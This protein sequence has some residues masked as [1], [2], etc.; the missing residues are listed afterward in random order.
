[1][2]K[3]ITYPSVRISGA[4]SLATVTLGTWRANSRLTAWEHT[5]HVAIYPIAADDSPTT[6][7]FIGELA[8]DDFADIAR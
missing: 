4:G 8:G 5:V 7:R 1:M 2:S 6:S 3:A